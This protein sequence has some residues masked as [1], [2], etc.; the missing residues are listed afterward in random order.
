MGEVAGGN[1]E[2]AV[3]RGPEELL[4]TKLYVPRPPPS[5][6]LRPRLADQLDQGLARTL[7]LVCAPAG[8]GKTSVL[9]DWSERHAPRVGWLSLD[10]GDNDPVRFWGHIAAALDQVRPGIAERAAPLLGSAPTSYEGLVTTVVNELAGEPDDVVLLLD[11]YHVIDTGSVHESLVF[12]IEHA[13]P[14]LHVVLASRAD[15]QFPLAR[16]RAQGELSELRAADLRFT[17]EE[18][19]GLLGV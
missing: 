19:A 17:L 12:L 14:H 6:V 9:A 2:Q 15:P 1:S 18:A 8:F 13:P 16:L 10:A 11:D 7:T 4:T 3:A 5:F